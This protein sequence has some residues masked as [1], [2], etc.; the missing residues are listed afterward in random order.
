[1]QLRLLESKLNRAAFSIFNSSLT[2]AFEIAQAPMVLL[3]CFYSQQRKASLG[4]GRKVPS[5]G[6]WKWFAVAGPHPATAIS[7]SEFVMDSERHD[8]P[9]EVARQR[10]TDCPAFSV[11]VV[12]PVAADGPPR[13]QRPDCI[14]I[15]RLIVRL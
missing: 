8:V 4:G 13:T 7:R 10:W 1:M 12:I 6:F 3:A 14:R 9:A 11:A 5:N 2:Y 15:G